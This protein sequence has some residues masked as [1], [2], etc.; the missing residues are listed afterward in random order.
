MTEGNENDIIGYESKVF[1]DIDK[2]IPL[3][4]GSDNHNILEYQ[5]GIFIRIYKPFL[6]LF[7]IFVSYK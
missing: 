6:S 7:T 5:F 4:R 2:I 1:P 3:V